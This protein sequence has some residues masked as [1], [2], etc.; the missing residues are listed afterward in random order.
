M[1]RFHRG[2]AE[3]LSHGNS[4]YSVRFESMFTPDAPYYGS[5]VVG[6]DGYLTISFPYPP[7]SLLMSTAAP[8]ARVSRERAERMTEGPRI[9]AALRQASTHRVALG[10]Y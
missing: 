6:P 3:A 1:L 7:L 9:D 2:S 4:P 8:L 5:G 10:G